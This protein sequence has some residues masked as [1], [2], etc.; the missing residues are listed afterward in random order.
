VEAY[1]A[2]SD[3]A[4]R[5]LI[6]SLA[7]ERP[8]ARLPWRRSAAPE[9]PPTPEALASLA[10]WRQ[11][12]PTEDEVLFG[13]GRPPR[14]V[15]IAIRFDAR[16]GEWL[17]HAMTGD[18]PLRATR[19]GVR[20]SSWRIDPTYEPQPGDTELRILV[21]EQR[22]AGGKF[23]DGRIEVP[24]LWAS[25]DELVL[26]M[27]VTPLHGFQVQAPNPETAVKVVL[28]E[29]IGER[30]LVDGAIYEPAPPPA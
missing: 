12:A 23:A 6:R 17:P 13:R 5:A 24:D 10:G 4:V 15:T 28:P 19:D 20:A 11:L 18:R 3:P 7:G 2:E 21:T 22:R 26:T 1:R 25:A 8:K 27:F 30:E 29:P 14:A 9:P 16:R